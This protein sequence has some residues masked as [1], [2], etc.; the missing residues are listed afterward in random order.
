MMDDI[1]AVFYSNLPVAEKTLW[2]QLYLL[3]GYDRV[4]ASLAAICEETNI[5]INTTRKH[6]GR[7]KKRG[8]L[9]IVKKYKS[10]AERGCSGASYQLAPVSTWLK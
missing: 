5:N 2:M 8:A 1:K 10:G 3:G 6:L 9:T 7:L 4:T